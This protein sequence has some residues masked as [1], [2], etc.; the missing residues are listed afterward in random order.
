MPYIDK[1]DWYDL[2]D[3]IYS[4]GERF[5]IDDLEIGPKICNA[6][7]VQAWQAIG[8]KWLEAKFGPGDTSTI[9]TKPSVMEIATLIS[10]LSG[11]E[12]IE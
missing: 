4:E 12:S 5:A 6:A 10:A 1:Q 9:W 3:A 11:I 7:M 8:K 2:I